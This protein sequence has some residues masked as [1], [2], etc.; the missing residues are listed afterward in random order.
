MLSDTEKRELEFNQMVEEYSR[1]KNTVCDPLLGNHSKDHD[2]EK[3]FRSSKSSMGTR[4]FAR[5]SPDEPVRDSS[6][7][8]YQTLGSEKRAPF[9]RMPTIG[10]DGKFSISLP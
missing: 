9:H 3:D 5:I 10:L 6:D 4:K 7:Q 2:N 8:E 1:C